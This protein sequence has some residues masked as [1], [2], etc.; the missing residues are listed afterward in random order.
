MINLF[1]SRI[2][3]IFRNHSLPRWF[4]LVIDIVAVF[5]TFLIA[6]MLRF[7]LELHLFNM[8]FA[9]KQAV[10]VCLVY[11][12]FMFLFKSYS[13]L[14]RQTTIK[15]TFIIAVTNTAS[16]AILLVITLCSRKLEF[17][18]FFNI[19]LSILM[20][21]YGA[22]TVALIFFR[23]SIKMFYVF[24]S[25]PS[26]SRKNVLIYGSGET[27]IIVKRV[28]ESD[29]RSGYQLTGFIDDNSKLQGKKVD[30]YPV[31]SK[32]ILTK[33]FIEAEGITVFIFAIK[34][35]SAVKKKEVLES[36][37]NL[38]L[39]IL[40]TP[41]FD[42]WLNG[43]LQVKQLRKVQFEDLLGR[44]P[45]TLDLERIDRG[46]EG[47]TILV[48]GA[49]GSIGSEIVRQLTKFNYK[50]MIL[51][52]QAE[53]P[54]FYLDN[55]LK[56][57]FSKCHYDLIIGD[58]TN[59]L[60][61]DHIFRKYRPEIV[62]HAAAYKHVPIMEAN[63]HEAF[64][65]NVGGTKVISELAI[66]YQAEK[67]VMISSDKAVN[68]TNVMG[69]TKQVCELLVQAQARRSEVKTKFV[70]TRFG[71]VLGS[72][73]SVIPLFNKQIAEGG[74]VT[75][76][77]PEI[78]RFFMTIPEA[79]QLV[80]EAGF[81]GNGGEI[82]IFDM[83]NPIKILD[84]AIRLIQL[85]GLEPYEDID[86]KFTGLRPGEKLFEELFSDKEQQLPT[87]NPKISIARVAETDYDYI[88][89]K[90]NDALITIYKKSGTEVVEVMKEIVP[91]YTSKY[92]TTT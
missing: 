21:H 54:S 71:N 27:G 34:D 43:H 59:E 33:D 11:M 10:F 85:S 22:V 31:Y 78:T 63:P 81:M 46:L 17:D 3:Q 2:I 15:D 25:V 4:V 91:G 64:R 52:D 69:A 62:F 61:M 26:S 19:P 86:I 88:L 50:R 12:V 66:K 9:V 75:I 37:I 47:K 30:G 60:K 83:G 73:G 14:I 90:I 18:L 13:G 67:F 28:I 77:D 68:P 55:E 56:D 74:P 45:I 38:G 39:E 16:F 72:N 51:L 36:V 58:V 1:K 65:V 57:K 53:T 8:N 48:T 40:D 24:V 29:P 82:F 42:K 23:V 41:S 5:L 87:H 44:E 80:L 7:N 20:I 79:C 6:Y 70:T 89:P 76:T 49:A 92:A 84:I 35:I 32:S